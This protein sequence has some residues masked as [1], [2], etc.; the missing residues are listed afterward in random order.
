M[1]QIKNHI[2]ESC[3]LNFVFRLEYH[4]QDDW[5]RIDL[6]CLWNLKMLSFWWLNIQ[7]SY[8]ISK[9]PFSV[10]IGMYKALIFRLPR[11]KC[12]QPSLCY[13]TT[14]ASRTLNSTTDSA[15]PHDHAKPY[16]L[17]GLI[18]HKIANRQKMACQTDLHNVRVRYPHLASF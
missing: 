16:K 2:I 17:R 10:L 7:L 14:Y 1:V 6:I 9:N 11:Y 4:F 13:Q 15:L 8:E 18:Q 3:S 5:L 12:P